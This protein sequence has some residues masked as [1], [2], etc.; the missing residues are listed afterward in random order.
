[1]SV[2]VGS[3]PEVLNSSII[4]NNGNVSAAL[5]KLKFKSKF[6]KIKNFCVSKNCCQFDWK[7][8][9]HLLYLV[10]T[11]M[12]AHNVTSLDILQ[13]CFVQIAN[14]NIVHKYYVLW[15]WSVCRIQE[16][17]LYRQIFYIGKDKNKKMFE[18]V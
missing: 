6:T 12:E 2:Y 10:N 7:T 4:S 5:P 18:K 8:T 11:V 9:R 13:V 17:Y 14:F 15:I 1:M 3:K 16:T